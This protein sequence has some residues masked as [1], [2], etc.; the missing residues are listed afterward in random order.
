M[1][2]AYTKVKPWMFY[3]LHP[4][5]LRFLERVVLWSRLH[6]GTVQQFFYRKCPYAKT[7]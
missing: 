3:P 4:H 7:S 2:S 6:F 5:L 1:V